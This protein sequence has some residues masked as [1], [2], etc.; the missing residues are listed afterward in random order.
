MGQ[1][2][3]PGGGPFLR[4]GRVERPLDRGEMAE[5]QL[6]R[7]VRADA[8]RDDPDL[9]PLLHL[10]PG[11]R[12]RGA[13]L[14]RKLLCRNHLPKPPGA[15]RG[16]I[17]HIAVRLG[18]SFMARGC[19]DHD[20]P[21]LHRE[22]RWIERLVGLPELDIA[23]MGARK[24]DIG[25][26]RNRDVVN[27]PGFRDPGP[28]CI[29]HVAEKGLDD[30]AVPVENRV[31][32]RVH[33]DLAGHRVELLADGVLQNAEVGAGRPHRQ[34]VGVGRG[35]LAGDSRLDDLRAAGVP[36]DVVGNDAADPHL[37]IGF[38]DL[39]VDPYPPP[40]FRR[41]QIDE[42]GRILVGMVDER[43][44]ADGFGAELGKDFV[45]RHEAVGSERDDHADSRI[46]YSRR[47]ALV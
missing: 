43:H 46:R 14:V 47:V 7:L 31:Q 34:Q 2:R 17:E 28:E 16:H 13:Y 42:R 22:V 4:K 39:A 24:N 9:L 36:G 33:P 35:L 10:R 1:N 15:V 30:L 25:L 44:P 3:Q 45:V 27:L 21:R 8:V 18:D 32:D 40:V 19:Y 20:A 5:S 6:G 37:E 38:D 41:S 29:R 26:L 12:Q 23:G 11:D